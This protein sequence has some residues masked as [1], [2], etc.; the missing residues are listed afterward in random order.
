MSKFRSCFTYM[1]RDLQGW[2]WTI[3][4]PICPYLTPG[5]HKQSTMPINLTNRMIKTPSSLFLLVLT[6]M[7]LAACLRGCRCLLIESFQVR[8][9]ILSWDLSLAKNYPVACPVWNSG[10]CTRLEIHGSGFHTQLRSIDFFRTSTTGTSPRLQDSNSWAVGRYP[11]LWK[12]WA[13]SF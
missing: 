9:L 4:D 6:S 8:T 2:L 11:V 7:C 10:Q 13:V 3:P 5:Y 1:D 12:C